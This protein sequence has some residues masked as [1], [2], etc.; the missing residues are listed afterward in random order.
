M[1]HINDNTNETPNTVNNGFWDRDPKDRAAAMQRAC[2][3][4]GTESFW[5]LSPEERAQA[6]ERD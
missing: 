6:Y 3:R 5:D 1:K 2:D 4:A